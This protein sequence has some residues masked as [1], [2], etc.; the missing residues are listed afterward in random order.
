MTYLK[1][2]KII[3]QNTD[4]YYIGFTSSKY[5]S[6]VLQQFIFKYK[7]YL[8]N[9]ISFNT[10]Y[11]IIDFDDI[12]IE[13]LYD[14]I[15]EEK[16]SQIINDYIIQNNNSINND[17]NQNIINKL[18]DINI[19]K[20]KKCQNKSEYLKNYYEQH[21]EKYTKNIQDK[22]EYYSNNKDKIKNTSKL[23]YADKIKNNNKKISMNI[24]IFFDN[25]E[26]DSD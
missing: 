11:N 3:S 16:V 5:L 15:E 21:K 1:I 2:Y 13:L 12:N 6:N 10:V 4:K 17:I 20:N 9:E 19:I 22:K 23:S 7:K 14:N 8:N 18:N 24:N 26:N 25:L